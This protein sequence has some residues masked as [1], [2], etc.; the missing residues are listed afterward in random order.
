M[1]KSK[2][3]AID[4]AISEAAGKYVSRSGIAGETADLK[5]C[6]SIEPLRKLLALGLDADEIDALDIRQPLLQEICDCA[7]REKDDRDPS[8]R[9]LDAVNATLKVIS[10]QLQG[11]DLEVRMLNLRKKALKR[12]SGILERLGQSLA[13]YDSQREAA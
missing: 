9:M 11:I 5:G 10:D 13:N 4:C 7:E 12:R 6:G 2:P 3:S 1:K 8:D